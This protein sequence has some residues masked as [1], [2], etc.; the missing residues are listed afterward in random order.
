MATE[1]NDDV[2]YTNGQSVQNVGSFTHAAHA[3][4]EFTRNNDCT[5][6]M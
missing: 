3:G 1:E 6:N 4:S 2:I 5:K